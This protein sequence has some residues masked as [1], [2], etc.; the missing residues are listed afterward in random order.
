[1]AAR[2]YWS[3]RQVLTAGILGAVFGLEDFDSLLRLPL[4][5]GRR[6]FE[7]RP[8]KPSGIVVHH[9]ATEPERQAKMNARAINQAHRRRHIRIRFQGRVYHIAYHYVIL[10][11]GAIEAGRPELCRGDHTLSHDYNS[12]IGIC[13][14]GYFDPQ[15]KNAGFRHP[16]AAQMNSLVTLTA[17]LMGRYGFDS[18]CILPH[19]RINATECPGRSFPMEQYLELV[20]SNVGTTSKSAQF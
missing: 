3:R 14:V 10:P 6:L 5:S 2:H 18:S 4:E 19:C 15:W 8:I 11:D 20:R 1:V 16:T 17:Q 12:W 7:S 9:S 13:L